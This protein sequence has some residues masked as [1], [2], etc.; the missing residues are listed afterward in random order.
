MEGSGCSKSETPIEMKAVAMGTI[1]AT[2]K[3]I[4]RARKPGQDWTSM[5]QMSVWDLIRE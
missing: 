3:D 4:P 2:A 5:R 1:E